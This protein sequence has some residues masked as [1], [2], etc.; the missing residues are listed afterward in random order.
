MRH[1]FLIIAS[2]LAAMSWFTLS[3][4]T[5]EAGRWGYRGGWRG[6][7][8]GGRGYGYGWRGGYRPRYYNNFYRPRTGIYFYY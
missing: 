3:S 5:A 2:V 8:Y 7:Y 4:S 1:K 6:G